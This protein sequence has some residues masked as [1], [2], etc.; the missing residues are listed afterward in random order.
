MDRRCTHPCQPPCDEHPSPLPLPSIVLSLCPR[1]ATC[2][3][4]LDTWFVNDVAKVSQLWNITSRVSPPIGEAQFGLLILQSCDVFTRS[5]APE[6]RLAPETFTP[7]ARASPR[8]FLRKRALEGIFSHSLDFL[9]ELD[10][11]LAALISVLHSCREGCAVLNALFIEMEYLVVVLV[12]LQSQL[13][14]R[15]PKVLEALNANL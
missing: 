4:P 15:R 5:L 7:P 6:A 12:V 2:A 1:Q 9:L 14:W 11:L 3:A 8:A 13:P 10:D